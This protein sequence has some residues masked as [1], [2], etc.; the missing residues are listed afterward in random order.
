MDGILLVSEPDPVSFC[1]GCAAKIPD[2]APDAP[3]EPE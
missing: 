1:F 2:T 3:G